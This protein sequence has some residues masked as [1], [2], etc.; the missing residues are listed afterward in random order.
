MGE[1]VSFLVYIPQEISETGKKYLKENGCKIIEGSG[2]DE[3]TLICESSDCDAILVRTAK[4]TAKVIDAN[5]RL[6]AIGRHGIGVENIDVNYAEKKGIWVT[7]GPASNNNSVAEAVIMLMLMC[8][9]NIYAVETTFRGDGDFDVRNRFHGYDLEGKTLGLIGL[10][11][12]GTLTAR[13]AT[14]GFGMKVIGYDMFVPQ[15][16]VDTCV[17][18]INNREE[19]F[20]EADFLSIHIPAMPSTVGSVTMSDFKMM[21]K[22]AYFI[23][24]ARGEIVKEADLVKALQEGIIAGAGL[25]VYCPEPPEVANPLLKMSNVIATPH[26]SAHTKESL[27]RMS[28]HAAMGIIDVLTGKIPLWPVNNPDLQIVRKT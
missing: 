2:I 10:G 11:K 19:V 6:K 17:E 15:E 25:D 8:A 5:V 24:C 18:F 22:T 16:K 1:N 14:H 27:D 7:N 23:N 3:E 21:K 12:I 20:R 4:I 26:N 28:L 9:R 13:K